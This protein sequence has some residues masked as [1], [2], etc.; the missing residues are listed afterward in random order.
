MEHI[1]NSQERSFTYRPR[2]TMAEEHE[3]LVKRSI[4][5]E[6]R[7][8]KIEKDINLISS[9]LAEFSE[10]LPLLQRLTEF[11]NDVFQEG[12]EDDE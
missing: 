11:E 8:S 5:A 2:P 9:Y 12:V 10:Y 7:L 1:D 4:R 3:G 6:A